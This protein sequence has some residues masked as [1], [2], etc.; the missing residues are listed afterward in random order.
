MIIIPVFIL[1]TFFKLHAN[2]KNKLKKKRR[3]YYQTK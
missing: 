1:F 2:P 3:I